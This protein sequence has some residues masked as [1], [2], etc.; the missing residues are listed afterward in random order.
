MSFSQGLSGLN[1]A[2]SALDVVGNNIA[3]SQ[4][5]GFKAGSIGFADIFAGAQGMGVQVAGSSQNFKDGGLT[6]TGRN[7]DMGI[8]GNGFFRLMD[9]AG[10]AYYSRNGQF[11]TDVNGYITNLTNGLRLTGYQATGTPP[12][13]Q[14]GAAVAPIQI[15]KTGMPP[16]AST[17]GKLSGNLTASA[18]VVTKTPF[19]HTDGETFNSS[20]QIEAF[21]SLGNRHTIDIYYVKTATGEWKAY[22]NDASAPVSS[23]TPPKSEYTELDIKF[24]ENGKLTNDAASSILNVKSAGLNGATPLDL[25]LD[26]SGITQHESDASTFEPVKTDGHAA[27]NYVNFQIGDNG[28]ITANYDNGEK[29]L[30]AQV[31]LANFANPGGLQQNGNN[32]W[33]ESPQSG[34]SIIGMAG[35]GSFGSL[36]GGALENSNVD[37]GSEMVNMIVYQR[38]YQSNSQTIKTQSEMLQTLVNLR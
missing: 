36:T 4:T 37:L 12:A 33:V 31:V 21:D 32:T 25:Q 1:A 20:S 24:D 18:E 3:N 27:G 6:G 38:N 34:G 35:T 5:F 29:Q 22:A 28:E 19:D 2:A 13:I 14:A 23:G 7:M 11:D 26:L 8:N 15:D 9:E 30:I 17:S 16:V 10:Q